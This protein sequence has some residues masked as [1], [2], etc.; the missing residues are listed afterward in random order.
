MKSKYE[1]MSKKE[2]KD[3][4]NSYKL[5]KKDI[6]KKMNNMF[7][8]CYFGIVYSILVFIYDFFYKHSRVNYILDI[9]IF[10]F[11]LVT[12]LKM[13]S[14]KKDLLNNYALKLNDKIKK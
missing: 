14:V 9:F 12:L 7:F 8:I 4:Y 3:L 11:S 6:A 5:E 1:R 13:Y 10:V 2:K